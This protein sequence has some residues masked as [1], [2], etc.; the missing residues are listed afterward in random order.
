[1]LFDTLINQLSEDEIVAVLG[2]E[3]GHWRMNH[4]VKNLIVMC[5]LVAPN[6]FK[7]IH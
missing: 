7:M 1:M 5:G 4:T 6:R 2:H 3:L